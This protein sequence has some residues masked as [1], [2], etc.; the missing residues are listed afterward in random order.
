MSPKQHPDSASA[1]SSVKTEAKA[2]KN[3]SID[4]IN[5]GALPEEQLDEVSAG[6]QSSGAGAGKITFNPF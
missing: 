6:S 4:K 1:Q 3:S 2:E 5:E